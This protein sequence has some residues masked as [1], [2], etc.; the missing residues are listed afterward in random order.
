MFACYLLYERIHPHVDGNGRM[1][2]ILFLENI[3]HDNMESFVPLSSTLR[4]I[5]HSRQLM[6]EIF[7]RTSFGEVMKKR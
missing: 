7:K 1:G 3:Y 5:R 4:N 6:D 2:R